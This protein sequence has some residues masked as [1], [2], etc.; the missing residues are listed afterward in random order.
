MNRI[1]LSDHFNFKRLLLF[2]YPSMLMVIFTSI[3]SIVDGV[4]VSNFGGLTP[5]AALN[6]IWPYVA[7]I[8]SI[9]FL[10][11]TGGCALVA[12][13][14]GEGED[15]KAKEIFSLLTYTALVISA[16]L[17][18]LGLFF[19]KDAAIFLGAEGEMVEHCVVYA[20]LLLIFLPTYVMQVYF[21][22]F[23]VAAER[24]KY[25]M[26]LT[27]AAGV[28]NIVF[29]I[30]FIGFLG[31]GIAGAAWAS[32]I[33]MAIGGYVPLYY[34]YKRHWLRKCSWDWSAL[35][36]ACSNGLSEL[37]L[38][39]SLSLVSM[40]Y[41]YQLIRQ[42]GE[43][44]VAAY[45]VISYFAFTFAS[46]FIGY[47]LGVSPV[48]SYHYGAGNKAEM[49]SLLKK[50]MTIVVTAG[51]VIA[52]LAQV[53]ARP[54]SMFFVGYDEA[55]L[56]MTVMAFRIYSLHFIVTG[57]NIFASEFFT[58]LNNG[59][60]SATIS[61]ARTLIFESCCV[62]LLP[63]FFGIEAIWWAVLVAESLAMVLSVSLI[64][65]YRNKYGY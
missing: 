14:M 11:G 64:Y 54:L 41:M 53:L 19:S 38:N 21:Q 39:I 4:M 31:M 9:G 50:S 8:G 32:I 2:T 42:S 27:I 51:I 16:I 15:D 1:Q 24:P 37:V 23:L 25:A 18:G 47:G 13:T 60:V 46:L 35:K 57:I 44:G 48:V 30:I 33:G 61:M 49:H 5:F 6:L 7:V 12:K 55:L 52:L 34:F 43:D 17:G 40:L 20:N 58:A 29:D 10:L 26:W 62:L 3:Y 59:P 22:S 45:G 28:S 65:K 63:F 36:Q 56:E